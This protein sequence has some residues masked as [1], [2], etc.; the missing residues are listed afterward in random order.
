MAAI[1]KV[2]LA[3]EAI[4]MRAAILMLWMWSG[5]TA[6]ARHVVPLELTRSSKSRLHAFNSCSL[7]VPNLLDALAD[8]SLLAPVSILAVIASTNSCERIA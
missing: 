6:A 7:A 2:I 8:S 4:P 3:A 1:L 5:T